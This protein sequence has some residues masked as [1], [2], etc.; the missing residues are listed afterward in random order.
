[1]HVES[2]LNARAMY[3][4]PLSL[5]LESIGSALQS[6][7][8]IKCVTKHTIAG[9]KPTTH[10]IA[11]LNELESILLYLRRYCSVLKQF[12]GLSNYAINSKL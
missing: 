7:V 10:Y 12:N 3:V 2:R 9:D 4:H 6:F 5:S 1:M 8:A 11:E